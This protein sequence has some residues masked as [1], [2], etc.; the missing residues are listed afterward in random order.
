MACNLVDVPI[1]GYQYTWRNNR[2]SDQ[3]VEVRLDRALVNPLWW[4]LF[5]LARLLNL[6]APISHKSSST[7]H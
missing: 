5:P 2:D 4:D 7:N 6:I 1:E 3:A